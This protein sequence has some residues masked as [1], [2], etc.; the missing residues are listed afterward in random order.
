MLGIKFFVEGKFDVKVTDGA[1]NDDVDIVGEGVLNVD[2]AAT[3]IAVAAWVKGFE[4]EEGIAKGVEV[5]TF[6]TELAES[7]A[8]VAAAVAGFESAAAINWLDGVWKAALI[9]AAAEV[10]DVGWKAFPFINPLK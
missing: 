10:L 8:N 7:I 2:A 5:T 6:A 9:A 3:A 4:V 1:I